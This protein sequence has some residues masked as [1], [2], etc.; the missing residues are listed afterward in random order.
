MG[1][2]EKLG[3]KRTPKS[4]KFITALKQLWNCPQE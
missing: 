4:K 2:F 1:T 3:E